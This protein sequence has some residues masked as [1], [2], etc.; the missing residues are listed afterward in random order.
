[1]NPLKRRL[2]SLNGL[3]TFEAA[4]R[5]LGFTRAAEELYVSQAAVSR[6]IRRLEQQLG[7]PLFHRE[8]RALKLTE[9]GRRL[10]EAVLVGFS[11]I[12]AVV[13]DI[14]A[15]QRSAQI[16]VATSVAFATYWFL[17]RL[18]AFR[19]HHPEA[20]VRV[21]AS[22]RFQDHLADDVDIALTCGIHDVPGWR[23]DRLFEEVVFPVCSP[24]YL[25]AH[26]VS[27]LSELSNH[28]LL[29]LD[30]RHWENIGWEPVDWPL[31]LKQFG[32]E[33]PTRAPTVT[34]NN[35]PML[36]EAALAGEGIALGWQH[37][38][39]PLL[40]QG[41]LVRP[42]PQEWDSGRSYYL[43]LREQPEP[44]PG[45]AALRDWLLTEGRERGEAE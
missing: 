31:W 2:P 11:H 8:H 15:V 44:S 1:M 28:T 27:G 32:I 3:V 10:Q 18:N 24:E 4:A 25:A 26:P 29:N 35:Y 43:A 5:H 17:P 42:V 14:G 12:A 30:P 23:T 34:F 39:E 22:D 6:Q 33:S 40:R 37:L 21:L 19:H 36:V 45:S 38:S 7:T 13:Q 41:R 9:A 20:D 16:Q